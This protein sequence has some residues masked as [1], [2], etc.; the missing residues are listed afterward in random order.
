MQN[1]VA[2]PLS[3]VGNHTVLTAIRDTKTTSPLLIDKRRRTTRIGS[4]W[5]V[6]ATARDSYGI[7]RFLLF[8]ILFFVFPL[9]ANAGSVEICD[10]DGDCY[11]FDDVPPC[12]DLEPGSFSCYDC[13]E[14]RVT[15]EYKDVKLTFGYSTEGR[16]TATKYSAANK[17][18]NSVTLVDLSDM[19]KG[20]Y[21][22]ISA[23][24][25]DVPLAAG[26]PANKRALLHINVLKIDRKTKSPLERKSWSFDIT[27]PAIITPVSNATAAETTTPCPKG[28]Y[29]PKCYPCLGCEP[30]NDGSGQYCETKGTK[31]TV[32][33]DALSAGYV[34]KDG[35]IVRTA[36]G[37]TKMV[38]QDSA[39]L[40]R[41]IL[42]TLK[43]NKIFVNMPDDMAGGDTVS[44]TVFTEA[45][46]KTASESR[47]QSSGAKRPIH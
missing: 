39:G 25:N 43:G 46:G 21:V 37:N 1:T 13:P 45:A 47:G 26:G 19:L 15:Q 20:G 22:G 14:F 12:A 44:G 3:G 8:M 30:C 7:R 32:N 11:V 29:P 23:K 5:H 27:D 9:S 35:K 36:A 17:L 40:H 28:T 34:L 2:A 42:T 4:A 6:M 10:T 18:L 24:I 33:P 31:M 16:I 38:T 41:V